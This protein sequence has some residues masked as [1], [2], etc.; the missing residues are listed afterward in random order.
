MEL[1][2]LEWFGFG[3]NAGLCAPTDDTFQEWLHQDVTNVSGPN[4]ADEG[5]SDEDR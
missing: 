4:C 5:D 3:S 1:T 2:A